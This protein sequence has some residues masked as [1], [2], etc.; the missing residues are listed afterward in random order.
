MS[1]DMGTHGRQQRQSKV[2]ESGRWD[3]YPVNG[4]I[5]SNGK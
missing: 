4:K 2:C 1:D 5:D 3:E